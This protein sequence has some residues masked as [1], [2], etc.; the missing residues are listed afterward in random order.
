VFSIFRGKYIGGKQ[1]KERGRDREKIGSDERVFDKS[2]HH[3]R[4]LD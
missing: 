2:A 1:D 4:E 3:P